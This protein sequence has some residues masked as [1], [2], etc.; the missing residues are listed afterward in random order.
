MKDELVAGSSGGIGWG[1]QAEHELLRFP[2]GTH[3]DIVDA[4]AWGARMVVNKQT[5]R[6]PSGKKKSSWKD[7]LNKIAREQKHGNKSWMGA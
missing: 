1:E 4:L 7:K 3:D 6:C 2:A 5:P